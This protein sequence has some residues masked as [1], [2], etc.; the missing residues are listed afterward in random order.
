MAMQVEYMY[1]GENPS[2]LEERKAKEIDGQARIM[3]KT[4]AKDNTWPFQPR[5][6]TNNGCSDVCNPCPVLDT[7]IRAYES[8]Y[9]VTTE[10][11]D[12]TP[13]FLRYALFK[14][15][16]RLMDKKGGEQSSHIA[17]ICGRFKPDGQPCPSYI[18]EL[19]D[20]HGM[21][22]V[23]HKPI[24]FDGNIVQC[25]LLVACSEE[26]INAAARELITELNGIIPKKVPVREFP[27]VRKVRHVYRELP[28]LDDAV[29]FPVL[30][31]GVA[32]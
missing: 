6:Q 14:L 15:D 5:F 29:A 20:T 18:D 11:T 30:G 27:A 2:Y 3:L 25:M 26:N 19:S 22:Y 16:P 24:C 9:G 8:M 21:W 28:K 7:V 32:V 31:R 13:H 12:Q 4:I 10:L 17:R 23:G 1:A